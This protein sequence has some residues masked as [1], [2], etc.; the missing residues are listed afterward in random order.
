MKL[1]NEARVNG[2][3]STFLRIDLWEARKQSGKEGGFIER[4]EQR[5]YAD[6]SDR[7]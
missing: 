7:A 3:E 1:W 5:I 2:V 4:A 6:E